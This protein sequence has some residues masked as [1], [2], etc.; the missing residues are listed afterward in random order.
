MSSEQLAMAAC[1]IQ[2]AWRQYVLR[3]TFKWLKQNLYRAE[4]SL[5]DE[6]LRR[7]S[8][9]EG[10]LLKDRVMQARVRFRFGGT[11]F[12]PKILYKIYTKGTNVHYF[13]GYKMIAP[14][15]KAAED[16]CTVMGNRT[17]Q[18]SIFFEEQQHR[19]FKIGRSYEVTDKME[20]VQYMNSL[21][22]KAP[23]L[24]GRNNGWRELSTSQ[25][26]ASQSVHYDLRKRGDRDPAW[27]ASL[28]LLPRQPENAKSADHVTA[29][30]FQDLSRKRLEAD[31]AADGGKPRPGLPNREAEMDDDFG[32]LFEWT[33]NLSFDH[34][35]DYVINE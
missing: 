32:L 6:V 19:L 24:G 11:C 4:R 27:A 9:N 25:L 17:Y 30:M 13:S 20:Y 12:P 29:Q 28:R 3:K 22:Y 15:S 14:G 8:P 23:H 2:K 10:K 18:E 35:M 31:V 33:N 16:S 21:D 7:L 26:A 34:L 1:V 5:T